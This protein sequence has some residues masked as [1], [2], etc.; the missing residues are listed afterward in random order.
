M[1]KALTRCTG[2][3]GR[4]KVRNSPH[5]GDMGVFPEERATFPCPKCKGSG[6][7][8]LSHTAQAGTEGESLA[9]EEFN[10]GMDM[11]KRR[12]KSDPDYT[13]STIEFACDRHEETIRRALTQA[14]ACP[15]GWRK[16]ETFDNRM[17]SLITDGTPDGTYIFKYKGWVPDNATH[18]KPLDTMPAAPSDEGAGG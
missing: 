6:M 9:L 8:A 4:G 7:T 10:C 13:L 5:A 16:I 1:N 11:M 14:P 15:E 18:W 3:R 2:C 17:F 12:L